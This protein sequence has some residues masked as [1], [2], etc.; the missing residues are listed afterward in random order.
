MATQLIDGLAADWKPEQYHD[1]YTEELRKRIK[2]KT[3]R[4]RRSSRRGEDQPRRQQGARPHGRARG[5]RRARPS[6]RAAGTAKAT[7]SSTQERV[8]AACRRRTASRRYRKKRDFTVTSEPS[9]ASRAPP[10]DRRS[11]GSSCSA[12]APR[13][14]HYDFRLEAD[15][16]LV[17]WAVP[18]GPTLDPDVQAHGRARRGPP[19][20]LLRLRGRHPRRRVRRRRRHRVGLG[21]LGARPRAT[22]RC[23]AIEAGDLHF[24]LARREAARPVR[25][26]PPRRARAAAKQWLLLHKH[27][28]AAVAGLGPRG[29]PAVGEVGPHQRR[30]EGGA[31]GDM[32]EHRDLG[33]RRPPTSSPRSTRSARAARGSS[34]STRCS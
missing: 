10:V 14:L 2:A 5:Q 6:D 7:A 34:A 20:R 22:T 23:D 29:P 19:A 28:D 18:K 15:G 25:A 33:R 31:G 1:T 32:V 21:H 12:T 9:G 27:D 30:G 17:S 8:E 24:D 3:R 16:V 11:T 4:A 13:R 26:R